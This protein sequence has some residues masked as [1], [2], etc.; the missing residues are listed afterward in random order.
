[1][2]MQRKEIVCL[3]DLQKALEITPTQEHELLKRL[4]RNGLILRLMRGV[5]LA[6]DKL[7]AGGYWQPSSFYLVAKYMEVL[8]AKY[9]ISGLF[10]FHYYG[11]IKQIPNEITVYNNKRAGIKSLG[12][13]SLRLIK[14]SDERIG[15]FTNI[16]TD[17]QTFVNIASLA[18]TVLDAVYDWKK[19][20]SLPQAY[21]WISSYKKDKNFIDELIK[22]TA[23]YGNVI[24]IR[25]IGYCIELLGFNESI[26]APLQKKLISK[27]GWVL[28]N[29]LGPKKGKTNKRWR[30]INNEN[31]KRNVGLL[32][33]SSC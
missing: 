7:P 5:Y 28:Y 3:G 20:N 33:Q 2:Q 10:A 9:Y 13:V 30:I 21:D 26:T 19:Y 6:P 32:Y 31:A 16:N 25:R 8:N 12:V 14:V 23:E 4:T 18:R 22:Q 27:T 24:T 29:P 1:V 11:L 15:G 17:K